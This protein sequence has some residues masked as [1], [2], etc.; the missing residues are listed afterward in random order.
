MIEILQLE[1][2]R[3]TTN[4]HGQP[5]NASHNFWYKRWRWRTDWNQRSTFIFYFFVTPKKR[6]WSNSTS[7]LCEFGFADVIMARWLWVTSSPWKSSCLLG[8][9]YIIN[10]PLWML[11]PFSLL[12]YLILDSFFL[13]IIIRLYLDGLRLVFFF[14]GKQMKSFLALLLIGQFTLCLLLFSSNLNW[15]N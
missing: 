10:F 8:S 11:Y 6:F 4:T 3:I 7:H 13:M 12:L 2:K 15:I 1:S 9:V 5:L 14:P